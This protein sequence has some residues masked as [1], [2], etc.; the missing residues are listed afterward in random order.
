MCAIKPIA[1]ACINVNVYVFMEVTSVHNAQSYAVLFHAI[2]ALLLFAF[3]AIQAFRPAPGRHPLRMWI[4][5]PLPAVVVKPDASN[6]DFA[7]SYDEAA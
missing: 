3:A 5:A 1:H 7:E 6:W 2:A 4:A